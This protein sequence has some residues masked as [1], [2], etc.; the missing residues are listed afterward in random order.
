MIKNLNDNILIMIKLRGLLTEEL[1]HYPNSDKI[2]RLL[3]GYKK[4]SHGPNEVGFVGNQ[5]TNPHSFSPSEVGF[6]HNSVSVRELDALIRQVAK[7]RPE[8]GSKS[9]GYFGWRYEAPAGP[10]HTYYISFDSEDGK[11]VR[12]F[13]AKI[14]RE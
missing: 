9:M 8:Q 6:T 14:I 4:Y 12:N 10:Y 11:T 3:K 2:E 1:T 5:P 13:T 7:P